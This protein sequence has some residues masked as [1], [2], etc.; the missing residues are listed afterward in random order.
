MNVRHHNLWP[1]SSVDKRPNGQQ[2]EYQRCR[3]SL[4]DPRSVGKK[5]RPEVPAEWGPSLGPSILF[6]GGKVRGFRRAS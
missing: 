4:V 2:P 6:A 5:G 1:V 3:I